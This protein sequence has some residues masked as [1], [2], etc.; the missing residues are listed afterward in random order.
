MNGPLFRGLSRSI[1]LKL[2]YSLK[3]SIQVQFWVLL[4]WDLYIV[5]IFF[6]RSYS[7]AHTCI[8]MGGSFECSV[9]ECVPFFRA[10]V[11]EWGGVWSFE[12]TCEYSEKSVIN[13]WFRLFFSI[14][15]PFWFIIVFE[16]TAYL[17]FTQLQYVSSGFHC[18]VIAGSL[19]RLFSRNHVV[20]PI[21]FPMNV[22]IAHKGTHCWFL[23]EMSGRNR[24]KVSLS[25]FTTPSSLDA[26]ET[27]FCIAK[28]GV[29]GV[30]II[31]AFYGFRVFLN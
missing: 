2:L 10:H 22:F 29:S 12:I 4:K 20:W 11:Y 27:H 19:M 15:T 21:F 3:L 26:S 23:F 18:R 30:Y 1:A 24:T 25:Y 31:S 28:L 5:W 6:P 9:Y 13:D 17:K 16:S 7:V 8:C 14:W